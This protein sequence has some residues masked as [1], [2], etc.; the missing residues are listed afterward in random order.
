[1]WRAT[2]AR[3]SEQCCWSPDCRTGRVGVG[4]GSHGA[5]RSPWAGVDT[6]GDWEQGAGHHDWGV[7][8]KGHVVSSAREQ[9]EVPGHGREAF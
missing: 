6:L 3:C 8:G 5:G 1:M 9:V 4:E 7:V 2:I